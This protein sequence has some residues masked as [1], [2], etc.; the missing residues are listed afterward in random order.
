V[1]NTENLSKKEIKGVELVIKALKKKYPFITGFN[2]TPDYENKYKATAAEEVTE[3]TWKKV[4]HK[5]DVQI[6]IEEPVMETPVAKTE[7]PVIQKP[8][9]K[10]TL[11]GFLDSI[12]TDIINLFQEEDDKELDEL[13]N[14]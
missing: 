12:K 3:K 4:A 2:I 8:D 7:E 9:R 13:K 11:K 6:D 10:K 1:P 5:A 14:Q